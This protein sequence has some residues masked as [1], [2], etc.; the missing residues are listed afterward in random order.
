MVYSSAYWAGPVACG[1]VRCKVGA[2]A[3][4]LRASSGRKSDGLD[5]NLH[6]VILFDGQICLLEHAWRSCTVPGGRAQ[7]GLAHRA[8]SGFLAEPTCVVRRPGPKH[9]VSLWTLAGDGMASR[10]AFI[11]TSPGVSPEQLASPWDLGPLQAAPAFPGPY[12]EW[13]LESAS[14]LTDGQ[15]GQPRTSCF[16]TLRA[17]SAT[18]RSERSP[19]LEG[20][21][22][23]RCPFCLSIMVRCK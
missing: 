4:T 8:V 13:C 9:R 2:W 3:P 16:P 12:S 21:A 20:R 1:R 18:S 6:P 11:P 15:R 23:P 17:S 5:R 19:G 7:A 10:A 14:V 22:A